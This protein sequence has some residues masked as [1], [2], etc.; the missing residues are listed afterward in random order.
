MKEQRRRDEVP[1]TDGERRNA[2]LVLL[3]IV[4]VIVG[5]GVWLAGAMLDARRADECM[6]SGRGLLVFGCINFNALLLI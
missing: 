6:P 3:A 5:G 4:I 1:Q 2:N